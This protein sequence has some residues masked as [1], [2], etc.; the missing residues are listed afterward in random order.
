MKGTTLTIR[1]KVTKAVFNLSGGTIETEKSGSN[2]IARKGRTVRVR[3]LKGGR[4]VSLVQNESQ[5]L[6]NSGT[7]KEV[8]SI[9][10]LR[11]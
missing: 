2:R 5:A 8:H 3:T 9:P 7:S 6:G 11:G 4:K 1:K 10:I